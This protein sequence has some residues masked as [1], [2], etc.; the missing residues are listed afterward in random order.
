LFFDNISDF[1]PYD[2][3]Q[4]NSSTYFAHKNNRLCCDLHY[5][6]K[7]EISQKFPFP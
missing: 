7:H 2:F 4:I 6:T 3:F 1:N 5:E